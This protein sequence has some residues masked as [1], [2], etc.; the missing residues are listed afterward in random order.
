VVGQSSIGRAR[1]SS[2]VDHGRR[3]GEDAPGHP[4]RSRLPWF[5]ASGWLLSK[6]LVSSY[7]PSVLSSWQRWRNRGEYPQSSR[8]PQLRLGL[9]I[10]AALGLGCVGMAAMLGFRATATRHASG[11]CGSGAG[12]SRGARSQG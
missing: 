6:L 8:V 12:V 4:Q 9:L 10:C 1:A 7:S 3:R 2:G 11:G 5:F